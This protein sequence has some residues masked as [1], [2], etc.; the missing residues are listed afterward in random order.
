[1]KYAK[2]RSERTSRLATSADEPLAV[3][4]RAGHS[5][6]GREAVHSTLPGELAIA[7]SRPRELEAFVLVGAQHDGRTLRSDEVAALRDALQSAG[8][9]WHALRWAALQRHVAL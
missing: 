7:F 2:A 4:L 8:L 9:E 5:V 1:L 3:A 6:A